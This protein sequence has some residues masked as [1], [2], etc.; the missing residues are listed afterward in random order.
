VDDADQ[1][2]SKRPDVDL[3]IWGIRMSRALPI[4]MRGEI[5]SARSGLLSVGAT[6]DDVDVWNALVSDAISEIETQYGTDHTAPRRV[7]FRWSE[8]WSDAYMDG[9]PDVPAGAI[10]APLLAPE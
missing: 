7:M 10:N 9:L 3:V 4:E 2:D 5:G 1:R 8:M 6:Q